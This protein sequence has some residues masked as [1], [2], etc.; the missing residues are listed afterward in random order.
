MRRGERAAV[1]HRLLTNARYEVLPTARIEAVVAEHLPPGRTVTVTASPAKGLEA[2]LGLT[3]RLA[4]QG[5]DA[6]PHL[7][8]RMISGRAELADIVQRL[9]A[10]GVRTVFV[11]AGDADPPA[12]PYEGAL[13][14]LE[15]LIDLGN[16]FAEVGITGYP[17]S[18]PS[19]HDDVTI[20]AMWDKRRHATQVVSNLTFDPAVLTGWVRRLRARGVTTPVLVGLPGP[21]ERTKLLAMATKIGVGASTKFLAKNRGVFARIA[22]PGGYDPMRLLGKAAAVLGDPAMSVQGLHVFTFNQ[23]AETEAWRTEQ[24]GRLAESAASAL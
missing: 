1:L 15:D 5:Y 17:E 13:A 14:L 2:T 6:V 19:I 23:V 16:P 22:A 9:R 4:A 8:A 12:G 20:Q 7:A 11:P 21:V 10:A 3:E 24:L 18:H